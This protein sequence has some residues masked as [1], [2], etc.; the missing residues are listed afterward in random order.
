MSTQP[1]TPTNML[2]SGELDRLKHFAKDKASVRLG[3]LAIERSPEI[4]QG[5]G[6]A[7]YGFAALAA[8]LLGVTYWPA[9]VRMFP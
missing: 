6:K 8:V 7:C 5:L 9:L 3:A 1:K 2:K 4:L